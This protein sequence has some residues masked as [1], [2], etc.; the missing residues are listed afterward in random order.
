MKTKPAIKLTQDGDMT[1]LQGALDKAKDLA[2]IIHGG[3]NKKAIDTVELCN[4]RG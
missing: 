2:R 3:A 1:I 4:L